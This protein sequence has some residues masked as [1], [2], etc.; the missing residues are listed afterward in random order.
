M[1]KKLLSFSVFNAATALFGNLTDVLNTINQHN[2]EMVFLKGSKS[3]ELYPDL[4]QMHV[5]AQILDQYGCWCY[6][7]RA[8]WAKGKGKPIDQFDEVCRAMTQA[9]ECVT[10]DA[11]ANNAPS[12]D[13]MIQSAA[14]YTWEVE[15]EVTNMKVDTILTCT[16]DPTDWCQA[17]VCEIDMLYTKLYLDLI[18]DGE[19]P[20]FD[21]FSHGNGFD[22]RKECNSG[23]DGGSGNGGGGGGSGPVQPYRKCCGK[24]PHRWIYRSTHPSNGN[25]QCCDIDGG[26]NLGSTRSRT[27]M[28][29]TH[30]CCGAQG[31]Q[32]GNS[33]L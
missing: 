4:L 12:C 7:G 27:Y 22:F 23:P 20:D 28:T 1:L 15:Y 32:A 29:G 10:K 9:Y 16:G 17:T 6:Q 26:N 3:H 19:E 25:R 21:R 5:H 33:C 31:V 13:P 14:G 11:A 2:S 8:N 30:T 24:Y 18:M